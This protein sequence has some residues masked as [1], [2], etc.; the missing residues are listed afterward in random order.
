M[1]AADRGDGQAT[2][3]AIISPL[4]WNTNLESGRGIPEPLLFKI[5]PIGGQQANSQSNRTQTLTFPTISNTLAPF[6]IEG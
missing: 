3:G 1:V 4:G 2:E 6:S 5:T